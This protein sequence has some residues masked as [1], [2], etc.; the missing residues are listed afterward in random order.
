MG[1]FWN[2]VAKIFTG[3]VLGYEVSQVPHDSHDNRIMQ[4]PQIQ[5]PQT[6]QIVIQTP[7]SFQ[8]SENQI[9]LLCAA[10]VLA[11]IAIFLSR[12]LTCKKSISI[13]PSIHCSV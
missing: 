6:P 11:V 7:A 8:M 12:K 10:V 2:K 1:K 9:L 3:A 13:E 4:A 5:A